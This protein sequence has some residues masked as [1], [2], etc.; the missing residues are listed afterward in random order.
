MA[1]TAFWICSSC[2]F[3]NT[4][5]AFRRDAANEK[6]EQCGFK[7][8]AKDDAGAELNADIAPADAVIAKRG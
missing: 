3:V 2:G 6:C 8:D 5:H 4:P 7:R 1:K